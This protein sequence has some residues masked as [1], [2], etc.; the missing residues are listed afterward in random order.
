MT[1]DQKA[2]D[3]DAIASVGTH[4]VER[5]IRTGSGRTLDD[6]T[7]DALRAGQLTAEDFRISREQLNEQADAAEAGGYRQLAESL[8]RAA[9]L[10]GLANERVF[11]IYNL[12]RPGRATAAELRSLAA[13]LE[14]QTLPRV[15]AFILEAAEACARRGI[16]RG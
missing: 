11:E 1:N 5:A 4:R 14:G 13:E 10:T 8:R 15:A 3:G 9:E 12:L 6:L 16:T 7:M 2:P